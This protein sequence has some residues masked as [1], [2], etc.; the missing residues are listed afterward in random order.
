MSD[1]SD[2]THSPDPYDS[3]AARDLT[4]RADR[5]DPLAALRPTGGLRSPGVPRSSAPR[6]SW[7]GSAPTRGDDL[8][9]VVDLVRARLASGRSFGVVVIALVVVVAAAGWWWVSTSGEASTGVGNSPFLAGGTTIP[10][11]GAT[12]TPDPTPDAGDPPAGG[13][14]DQAIGD[15]IVVHAAGAVVTP[16]VHRLPATARIGDLVIAAGGLSPEA[17]VDRLNLAEPLGDG[18][19]VY[20]PTRGEEQGPTVAPVDR[21]GGGTGA[22]TGPTSGAG[23]TSGSL[24]API[25]LNRATAEELDALP[26]VGPATAQAIIGFRDTNGP[27]GSVDALLEVRG[28]GPAK[29]EQIRPLVRA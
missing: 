4:D 19:R 29:L 2:P 20:V 11:A 13:T 6:P 16:G 23:G 7:S 27:F 9:R 21:P 22:T 26:G 8:R 14:A 18:V 12:T 10:F 25:D 15:E 24:P 1:A 17:D 3:P 5:L 28:I